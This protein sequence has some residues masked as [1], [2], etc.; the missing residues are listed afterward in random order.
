MT[1]RKPKSNASLSREQLARRRYHAMLDDIQKNV[2]YIAGNCMW[3]AEAVG[4]MRLTQE[5]VKDL[6]KRKT[7]W[8]LTLFVF[9]LD[10]DGNRHVYNVKNKCIQPLD[11]YAMQE[12]AL[13][14]LEEAFNECSSGEMLDEGTFDK[15]ISMGY[16]VRPGIRTVSNR[17]IAFAIQFLEEKGCWNEEYCR[18]M[19]FRKME[20]REDSGEQGTMMADISHNQ[21]A[22]K[23]EENV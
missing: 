14:L 18:L 6:L 12:H 3:M 19:D 10:T 7:Q 5:N 2:A 17:E 16:Y 8:T 22:K 1:K 21:N 20:H 9:Y 11:R 4:D 15:V 23:E 13:R